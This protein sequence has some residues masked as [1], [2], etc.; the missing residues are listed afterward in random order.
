MG[1]STT[2]CSGAPI[3]GTA[4]LGVPVVAATRAAGWPPR[5]A[6]AGVQGDGG[7]RQ[8]D[9]QQTGAEDRAHGREPGLR[10]QHTAGERSDGRA[11]RGGRADEHRPAAARVERGGEPDQIRQHHR[12]ERVPG[13]LAGREARQV[14][15]G[16]AERDT[17]GDEDRAR[18]DGH[19][20]SQPRAERARRQDP[21]QSGAQT[22]G[23]D[24][25]DG[26]LAQVGLV[27]TD[28]AAHPPQGVLGE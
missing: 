27:K 3:S 1:I 8:G 9:H 15:R 10:R 13:D 24:G 20:T 11:Q 19:G 12:V 7:H 16:G 2:G 5:R 26:G 14:G 18:P 21:G 17:A 6:P 4:P 22:D 25:T 28:P 23:E